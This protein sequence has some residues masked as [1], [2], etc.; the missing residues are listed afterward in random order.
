MYDKTDYLGSPFILSKFDFNKNLCYTYYRIMK[1]CNIN[2]LEFILLVILS[3]VLLVLYNK[4]KTELDNN[5][6]EE[7][8]Q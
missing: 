5:Y 8:Y 2:M 4:K 7:L 6:K 3:V 1:E